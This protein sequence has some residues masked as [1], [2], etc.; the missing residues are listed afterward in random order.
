MYCVCDARIVEIK[1]AGEI[2]IATN[3]MQHYIKKIVKKNPLIV[4]V[5]QLTNRHGQQK[6]PP[7]PHSDYKLMIIEKEQ[8]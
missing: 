8:L 1:Q 6:N 7:N 2:R 4:N 5:I 3:V